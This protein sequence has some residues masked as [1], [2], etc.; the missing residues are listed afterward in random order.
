V[1]DAADH[2]PIVNARLAARVGRQMRLD[3]RK[4]RVR[5]PE[6]IPIHRRFLSE[7]VNHKRLLMPTLLWVRTLVDPYSDTLV[8]FQKLGSG[9]VSLDDWGDVDADAVLVEISQATEAEN[10]TRSKSG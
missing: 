6:L 2:A 7:A 3:L 10:V 5:Q 1:D 9:Y 8:Y 4:L